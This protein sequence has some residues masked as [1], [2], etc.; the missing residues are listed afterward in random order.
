M[1]FDW[2]ELLRAL[3]LVMVIEGLMPF[4][5]PSQ[6]RR[7]LFTIAQLENRSMRMIGFASMV[8]GLAV[9]QFV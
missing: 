1:S 9:L 5:A 2:T 3:A 4:A 6:W 7:T 8:A